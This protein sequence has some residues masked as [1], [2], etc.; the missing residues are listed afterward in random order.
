MKEEIKD[1]CVVTVCGKKQRFE[2]VTIKVKEVETKKGIFSV[3]VEKET[4]NGKVRE[5]FRFDVWNEEQFNRLE[6]IPIN[7]LVRVTSIPSNYNFTRDGKNKSSYD[8][9]LSK[10]VPYSGQSYAEFAIRGKLFDDVELGT[11]PGKPYMILK[12]VA[13]DNDKSVFIH[14]R[15]YGFA[16]GFTSIGYSKNTISCEGFV[17]R[18]LEDGTFQFFATHVWSNSMEE[19]RK[20]VV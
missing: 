1:F 7:A 16:S 19:D 12:M 18:K 3:C 10:V 2:V 15:H 4:K 20:S 9:T 14:I 17:K 11:K 6:N 5:V 13:E 8:L